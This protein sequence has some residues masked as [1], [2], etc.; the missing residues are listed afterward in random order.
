MA[1]KGS[2]K[3]GHKL[4]K[5]RPKGCEN[6]LTKKMKT[7]KETVLNAFNELQ[8]DPQAN[9]IA[10]AK[11]NTSEFYT[12]AAKLIPTEISGTIDTKIIT[13]IPPDKKE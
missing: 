2:F 3:K 6:E 7:V 8:A 4:S 5:G 10:W 9:I 1:N 13:V 12:I 11:E